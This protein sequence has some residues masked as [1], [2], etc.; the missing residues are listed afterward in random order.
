MISMYY[1]DFCRIFFCAFF[2]GCLIQ[3]ARSAPEWTRCAQDG[4]IQN[5]SYSPN[6]KMNNTISGRTQVR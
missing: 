3:A 4:Y 5:L 6:R 2:C 1:L